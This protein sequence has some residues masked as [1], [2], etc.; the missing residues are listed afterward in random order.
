MKREEM[1]PIVEELMDVLNS[2][3]VSPNDAENIRDIFYRAVNDS[4][5]I[6]IEAYKKEAAFQGIPPAHPSHGLRA[7]DRA[8]GR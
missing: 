2:K 3:K 6:A 7:A 4:I 8:G 5:D 1:L